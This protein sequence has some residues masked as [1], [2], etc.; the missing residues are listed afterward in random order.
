MNRMMLT[1]STILC[2]F[3]TSITRADN[4]SFHGTLVTPP[5]CTISNGTTIEVSF[6]KINPDKIDGVNYLTD[7]P[8]DLT[9]DSSTSSEPFEFKLTY[10]GIRSSYSTDTIA[11]NINNLGIKLQQNGQIFRPGTFITITQNALP[12]LKAVP[13]KRPGK[14]LTEGSFNAWATLQVDYQ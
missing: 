6:G 13:V 9:C 1:I 5:S 14:I 4:L 12:V 10:L 8:W 7:V 11:T 2:I 3:F